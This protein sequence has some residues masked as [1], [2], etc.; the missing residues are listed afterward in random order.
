MLSN[1]KIKLTAAIFKEGDTWIAQCLNFDIT[2]QVDFP[3][4]AI[5]NLKRTIQG[6]IMVDKQHNIDSLSRCPETPKFYYDKGFRY[7]FVLNLPKFVTNKIIN[8]I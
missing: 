2:G 7:K 3:V 1:S 6:Q 4:T 8:I 5:E